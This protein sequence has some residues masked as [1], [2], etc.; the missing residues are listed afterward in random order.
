MRVRDSYFAPRILYPDGGD[1]LRAVH[2]ARR[3]AAKQKEEY[4]SRAT[5]RRCPSVAFVRQ[6]RDL[7]VPIDVFIGIDLKLI[8]V[9]V[10]A[11]LILE[12]RTSRGA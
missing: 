12:F 4:L 2:E 8:R 5:V 7:A 6:S 9:F 3:L 11:S 10:V 1:G